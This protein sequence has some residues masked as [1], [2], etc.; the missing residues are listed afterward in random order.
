MCAVMVVKGGVLV[1]AHTRQSAVK[2]TLPATL[3]ELSSFSNA[4][5]KGGRV[6][7]TVHMHILHMLPSRYREWGFTRL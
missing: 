5:G 6:D 2:V 1:C 3:S 4:T 7:G